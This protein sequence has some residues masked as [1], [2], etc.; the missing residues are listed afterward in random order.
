MRPKTPFFLLALILFAAG[1]AP[2]THAADA[3]STMANIVL[4]LQHFPSDADKA[5]LA[6]IA[7]GDSSDSVKAVAGAIANINHKVSDT[8]KGVLEAIAND[9]SEPEDLRELAVI[10]AGMNHMPGSEDKAALEMLAS[11]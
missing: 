6:E 7:A 9:D 11:Q 8:D 2:V 10:V 5:A 4:S 3:V 1:Y